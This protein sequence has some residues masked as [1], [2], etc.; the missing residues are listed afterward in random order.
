MASDE[1]GPNRWVVNFGGDPIN[2]ER[3]PAGLFALAMPERREAI[4]TRAEV[5]TLRKALDILLD[6]D[7]R[8]Q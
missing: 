5:Q 8:Q 2:L 6:Q 4:G 1:Q 7:R 3:T